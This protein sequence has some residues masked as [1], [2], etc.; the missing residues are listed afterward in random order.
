LKKARRA[1]EPTYPDLPGCIA[2]A[3]TKQE[4]LKLIQEAI[5]FHIEGL[6]ESGQPIPPAASSVEYVDVR[7][8]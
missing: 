1:S 3:E 4:V 8:A 5:E 7:A 2:V 6:L